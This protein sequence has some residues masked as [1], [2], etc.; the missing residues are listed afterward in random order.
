M[1][2]GCLPVG[3]PIFVIHIKAITYFRVEEYAI[4]LEIPS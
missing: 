4:Y 3:E 1:E 2:Y